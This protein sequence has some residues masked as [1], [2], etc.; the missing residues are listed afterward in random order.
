[1]CLA[2]VSQEIVIK[3]KD[4]AKRKEHYHSD[5]CFICLLSH[6]EEGYIFGTDGKRIPLDEIFL[7]FGNTN[8]KGLMGKPKVFIIQA[9]RGGETFEHMPAVIKEWKVLMQSKIIFCD[10]KPWYLFF[11]FFFFL[12]FFK[13]CFTYN[14]I[15]IHFMM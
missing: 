4:F 3:L 7:L 9:C 5:A 12:V 6:G 13:N 1:M 15:H 2:I 10:I 11:F 14:D 8:C